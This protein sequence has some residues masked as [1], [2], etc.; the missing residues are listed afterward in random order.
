VTPVDALVALLRELEAAGTTVMTLARGDRAAEPWTLYP[1]EYGIVDRQTRCQ[2]YYHSH[3]AAHEDGHF[4][5][6][7]LFDDH[8]VHL[9][10]ISMAESGW[11][12]A[13]FTLNLWG[14]GDRHDTP[15]NLKR[16]VRRFS[17]RPPRGDPR[18]VRFVNLVFRAFRPE[19]EW[20]QDEKARAIAAYRTAHGGHDPFEDR[21]VEILSRVD[22]RFEPR[23]APTAP[24][25]LAGAVPGSPATSRGPV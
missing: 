25:L 21:S 6:V 16:Y 17:V 11:P 13:L 23:A 3:G 18:L 12:Q 5:T 2:F 19:I 7:R 24:P 10:G 9:V 1:D 22:L 15:A 20:L 4:H 8:T 14:I